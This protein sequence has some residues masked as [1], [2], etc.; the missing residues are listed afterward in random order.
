MPYAIGRPSSTN[1]S[2]LPSF[3]LAPEVKLYSPC[4]DQKLPK[5][6]SSSAHAA[7]HLILQQCRIQWQREGSGSIILVC[8]RHTLTPSSP[9]VS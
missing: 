6:W 7:Q 9:L 3:D 8:P 4:L 2:V 1:V 5:K